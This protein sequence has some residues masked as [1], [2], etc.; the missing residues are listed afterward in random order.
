V[1]RY[2]R[3]PWLAEFPKSRVPS[4][5]RHRGNL[6]AEVA[7]VGGGLTGCAAAYAFAAAGIEVVLVEA[8]SVGR[9]GTASGAGWISGD[10]GVS[11]AALEKAKGVR[12]ARHAFQ[13]WRHAALDLAALVRRLDVKCRL[14]P[15]SVLTIARTP[16]QGVFLTREQKARKAAGLDAPSLSA[17]AVGGEAAVD[18]ARLALRG[19]DNA[20]LDPYRLCLGLASAAVDR[21]ARVFEHSPVRKTTFTRRAA[22]VHTVGGT[23]RTRRIVVATGVPTPLFKSLQRHFWFHT[24]YLALTNPVP[25]KIRHQLGSHA[26]V[27]RDCATPPH[28]VRWVGDQRLLVMGADG[29]LVPD[30]QRAQAVVQRTG[31]LMYEL[32]VLYPDISGILPMFGWDVSYG[33]TAEGLPYIGPHRNFP[34]HLFAFGDSSH[35]VTGAFLAGRLLLRR[36]QD[37]P[38]PAD[39]AFE[40]T[41]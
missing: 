21:G 7:I 12:L 13:A 22:Q 27:V 6:S 32:S 4:Y 5:P 39:R 40:F 23:I 34:H 17:R 30:R 29:R 16:E 2:G 28:V 9:A 19:R 37:E 26:S 41:R 8:D 33:R 36:H 1:T 38:H 20:V 14:E 15:R 3:S 10:P 25:A 18:G 11:F 35:S 31:Q 24:S